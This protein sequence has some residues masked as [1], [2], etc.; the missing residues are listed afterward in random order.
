M[1]PVPVKNA[2]AEELAANQAMLAGVVE[3]R[4]HP[5]VMELEE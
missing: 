1:S 3:E 5:D 2:R 4:V